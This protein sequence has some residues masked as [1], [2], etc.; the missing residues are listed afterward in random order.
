MLQA[1]KTNPARRQ[2]A[3][4]YSLPAS[5]GGLNARDP[6]TAMKESDALILENVFPDANYLALRRGYSSHATGLGSG[7]VETLMTYHALNG[8]EKLFGAA[9]LAIYDC[10]SAGA[11]SS[12]Y[13]TSITSN[14]WQW[15]DFSTTAQLYILAF[16]GS[17]TPLKYD[18]SNW[19]VNT[20]TGSFSSSSDLIGGCSHKERVWLIE[21]NK[22]NAWY[23]ASGAISSTATKFPLTGVFTLGGSLVAL[24]TLSADTGAGIDDFFVAVTSNGEVAVY[25]GTSPTSANTWALVGVYRINEPLG[26]RCLTKFGGDLFILTTGG[27]ISMQQALKFDRAQQDRVAVTAKIQDDFNDDARNY[28]DNFGWQGINYPKAHYMLFNVPVVAGSSQRQWVQNTNKGSW[29]AFTG[30][31]ANCWGIL[32]EQLYFGG[33]AGVVYK[34]DYGYQDAGGVINWDIKTA[35]SYFG[36]PGRLKHFR[37]IR[38]L[39]VS[40][41]NLDIE[42]GVNVDF[43]NAAPTG[44]LSAASGN[45][46]VWGSGSSW[47]TSLWGGVG[48]RIQE[49][50]TVGGIGYAAAVRLKGQSNGV[51]MQIN[52]FD[53][54]YAPGGLI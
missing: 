19:G 28:R 4:G 5:V 16:N 54:I 44:T 13:S 29:C 23:L 40:S 52:G 1:M 39:I 17:D 14:R 3:R 53:V 20:I 37:M 12:V 7:V 25:Q 35:F 21:K 45:T 32:D 38:P 34:A 11:A 8:T 18:G 48:L 9:N 15:F 43:D 31:N 10:T 46:G 36:G 30:L 50:N 6:L 47:G 42:I 41:G 22:L 27:I 2:T 24:G 26:Y 51:A 33:N 49:W